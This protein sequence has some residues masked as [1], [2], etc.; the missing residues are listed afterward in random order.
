VAEIQRL[1]VVAREARVPIVFSTVSYDADLVEAGVWPRKIPGQRVLVEGTR[2]VEIDP[3]L[4]RRPDETLLVKKYASC[5]FGTPLAAQLT[6]KGVDTIVVTGVTTS[7]C[8]RATAVDG[9]SAGFRVIV[10]RQAVSDRWGPSHG[11][12]LFDIDMKYG[13]VVDVDEALAYLGGAPVAAVE[14]AATPPSREPDGLAARIALACRILHRHGHDHL[15]FGHVSGRVPGEHRM[16][17]KAAGG[18][19]E[20]VGAA[21]VVAVDLAD[22]SAPGGPAVPDELPLHRELYRARVHVGGVV[23]THPQASVAVSLHPE[24]WA[25]ACQD[26]V[27]FRNRIAFHDAAE[28]VATEEAGRRLAATLGEGRAVLL[29][30]HGLVT[31]GADVEEATVRAVQLERALRLQLAAQS[32]G[33]VEPL[34]DAEAAELDARFESRGRE[35]IA[36]IWDYL[37]RSAVRPA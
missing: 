6:A 29:R 5:F 30:G 14:P 20:E 8:V 32:L 16:L 33:P 7:G 35:R 12:S 22:G 24:R 3:R 9:C 31:V 26:A 28:L 34:P 36:L 13:D 15:C 17:I 10:P 23:H 25:V 27:P 11:M 4:G 18:G 1:L 37:A 21:D 19:L 2:W